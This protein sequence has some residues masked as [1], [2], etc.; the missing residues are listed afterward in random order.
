M[1]SP[2]K[3]SAPPHV[4]NLDLDYLLSVF[5]SNVFTSSTTDPEKVQIFD[6]IQEKCVELFNKDYIVKIIDNDRGKLSA[7]YP[8]KIVSLALPARS[9]G[10]ND[11][12]GCASWFP[13]EPQ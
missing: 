13:G 9:D 6:D 4:Q 3:S 12:G 7:T 5:A 11:D 2:G 8:N 10:S 1:S